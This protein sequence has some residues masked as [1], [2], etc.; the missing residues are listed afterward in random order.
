MA[1]PPAS[2]LL[3]PPAVAADTMELLESVSPSTLLNILAS[4]GVTIPAS[5]R[6]ALP[7]AELERRLKIMLSDCQRLKELFALGAWRYED[8]PPWGAEQTPPEQG[9]AAESD[10]GSLGDA[11][12]SFVTIRGAF[13][14]RLLQECIPGVLEHE[15]GEH[16]Y[17]ELCRRMHQVACDLDTCSSLDALPGLAF[18]DGAKSSDIAIK[19][20]SIRTSP[21]DKTI[22]ILFVLFYHQTRDGMV[23]MLDPATESPAKRWLQTQ[24]ATITATAGVG[25]Q[26]LLLRQLIYNAR[27]LPADSA[28]AFAAARKSSSALTH[29]TPSFL[30]PLHPVYSAAL[31]YLSR[32]L[33]GPESS[34]S[35]S[36]PTCPGP[37]AS[38]A[39]RSGICSRCSV[40]QYCSRECQAQDLPA[41]RPLCLRISRSRVVS[42]DCA[43]PAKYDYVTALNLDSSAR[44]IK[45]PENVDA[46]TARMQGVD[47]SRLQRPDGRLFVVKA[48]VPCG[49]GMP[50]QILQ[51]P[52]PIYDQERTLMV[53]VH[54]NENEAAYEALGR[55]A[56]EC[57]RWGGMKVF[58][59]ARHAKE[60]NDEESKSQDDWKRG[61]YVLQILTDALPAQEVLW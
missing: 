52:I 51:D 2:A 17:P 20:V 27:R 34:I 10:A 30:L 6:G 8:L 9:A 39:S 43:A 3:P 21:S 58:L 60:E 32:P 55:L 4:A 26:H 28:A 56:S 23:R 11:F 16:I 46:R 50:D 5:G 18:Q 44:N 1:S 12:S 41:H 24:S 38:D 48:Q 37:F 36:A 25:E 49:P 15:P 31:D 33:P 57:A 45:F 61:R 7:R 14:S 47:K 19:I 59:Y 42:I 29:F 53:D 13:K 40:A 35:C 54:Q 22:P